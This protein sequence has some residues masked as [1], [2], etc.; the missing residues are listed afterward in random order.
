M[1]ELLAAPAGTL[2][3]LTLLTNLGFPGVVILLLVVGK[4]RTEGEVKRLESEAARKDQI[5]AQKDETILKLQ[6]GLVDQAIPALTRS[7]QVR[8]RLAP[9][10]E[11]RG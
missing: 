9:L 4:L 11:P 3:P 8:E 6:A 10:L 5:I 7:T 1:A 2:D